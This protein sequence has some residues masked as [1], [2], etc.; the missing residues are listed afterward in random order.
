MC[1]SPKS[2]HLSLLV[3]QFL[4]PKKKKESKRV[5]GFGC[6][7]GDGPKS[8]SD[9]RVSLSPPSSSSVLV[10]VTVVQEAVILSSDA[11]FNRFIESERDG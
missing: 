11:S 8:R 2:S 5:F 9:P 6:S 3:G 4:Q 7:N 1:Q 10:I